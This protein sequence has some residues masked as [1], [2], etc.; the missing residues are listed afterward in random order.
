MIRNEFCQLCPLHKTAK[1]VCIPGRWIGTP[2][3]GG[4]AVIGEAPGPQE[5]L[6]GRPFVG[7]SGDELHPKL[8]G[9]GITDYFVSNVVRCFPRGT[10]STTHVAACKQYLRDELAEVQ[11]QHILAL[12]NTAWHQF[13]K[14]PIT[15]HAGKEVWNNDYAAWVMPALHPAAILRDPNKRGAWVRDLERFGRLT[16]GELL[17]TPP[18]DIVRLGG[19]TV[20]AAST[21]VWNAEQSRSFTFDFEAVPI[22]WW[23][24]DWRPISVAFSF[25]PDKAYVVWLDGEDYR[26]FFARLR[27][28][29]LDPTISKTAHN[30]LYDDLVWT[31]LAGYQPFTTFDTMVAAQLLDENRQKGLK[32]LGRSLLGWPQWDVDIR[33]Q[34]A[35]PTSKGGNYELL[36]PREVVESYN[37]Y[38]T[39]ATFAL[40]ALFLDQLQQE[41]R[42]LDYMQRLEMPKLRALERLML[43]GIAVDTDRIQRHLEASECAQGWHRT[44]IQAE[45]PGSSQQVAKWL[46]NTPVT[47]NEVALPASNLHLT[48]VKLTDGGKPSTDEESIK[49]LVQ[50]YPEHAGIRHLLGYRHEAKNQSTYLR[51]IGEAVGLAPLRRFHPDYRSTSVETGRLGSFF[52]TTPREGFIRSVFTA[53][54]GHVLIQADFSQIEA[55]LAAWAAAGK[56]TRNVPLGSM[57]E[58]WFH[59]RDVYSEQAGENLGKPTVL[60][61]KG[62][63]QEMGK[64]PVL[65]M[66]YNITPKG[67]REYA[68]R[69]YEIEWTD[70]QAQVIH[71]GFYRRWPEF[72][73]W[74]E[75]LGVQIRRDGFVESAVGRRRRLPAAQSG[76]ENGVNWYT[77]QQAVNSGINQPIQSVASDITQAAMIWWDR[78][79]SDLGGIVGNVHDALLFEAPLDR[80]H[81]SVE[82]IVYVMLNA[83]KLLQPLG[84]N[85][86]DGLIK[87]E[88]T[89][90]PWGAGKVIYA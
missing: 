25:S 11:P 17:S 58:A 65:S 68:W 72:R 54:P 61:T 48:P 75:R 34:F 63:R 46:F 9:L 30:M 88:L 32:Y 47:A 31:R 44:Y 56:P 40:R 74:H 53:R 84:L 38:D 21:L 42:L 37:G 22:P 52:H 35:F 76:K 8:A 27:P 62:E 49:R 90:G 10:P 89:A 73:R 20:E 15:E 79:Y 26:E 87:V 43:R 57:L 6:A 69:E 13:G 80:V 70:T 33:K 64:V 19:P 1:N 29:M 5:D 28:T 83:W 66:L 18:V 14:G 16:R 36:M 51:P 55:R 7:A 39:A 45:N 41:P 71:A 77:V 59:G 2:S 78:D 23:H 3:V 82:R 81:T 50:Q 60:V 12:G 67:L 85:L 86:P 4:I 24:R